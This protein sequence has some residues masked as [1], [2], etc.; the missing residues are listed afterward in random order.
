MAKVR[1]TQTI[2][3]MAAQDI[4]EVKKNIN[5]LHQKLQA[6]EP[7][8]QV[9]DPNPSAPITM[10]VETTA[11]NGNVY[12]RKGKT[13]S[14]LTRMEQ[15]KKMDK[16]LYDVSPIISKQKYNQTQKAIVAFSAM[17]T[18]TPVSLG[19]S[20]E[21]IIIKRTTQEAKPVNDRLVVELDETI[22]DREYRKTALGDKHTTTNAVFKTMSPRQN[23]YMVK[24]AAK[25]SELYNTGDPGMPNVFSSFKPFLRKNSGTG[26]ATSTGV[27]IISDPMARLSKASLAA[28]TVSLA[29]S[30]SALAASTVGIGAGSDDE[31]EV[32]GIG[33][34]GTR[35]AES[36]E[37]KPFSGITS[38]MGGDY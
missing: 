22:A 2:Q 3:V 21:E 10:T 32:A 19:A 20:A 36:Q 30:P 25:M 6:Q 5:T 23:Q 16:V 14:T 31:P 38:G 26:I 11:I 34:E 9:K 29:A 33:A 12:Q 28:S 27:G 17:G 24:I 15:N 18:A 35:F 1:S 8:L 7:F 37:N 13:L 4:E